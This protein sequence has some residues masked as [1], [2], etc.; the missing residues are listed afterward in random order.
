MGI[1]IGLYWD[2]IWGV[3]REVIPFAERINFIF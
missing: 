2:V 1:E 3:N